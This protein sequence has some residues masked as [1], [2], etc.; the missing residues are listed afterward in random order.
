MRQANQRD[1]IKIDF[2]LIFLLLF[3]LGPTLLPYTHFIEQ[4][5]YVLLVKEV[6]MISLK[7]SSTID[8]LKGATR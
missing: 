4:I 3:L 7:P 6:V 8:N 5:M 1:S 2:L